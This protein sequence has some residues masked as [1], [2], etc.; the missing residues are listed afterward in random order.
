MMSFTAKAAA[1]FGAAALV[2]VP[3]GV[4]TASTS[5]S[6]PAASP[7]LNAPRHSR[8][9]GG[10]GST[11]LNYHGGV[12]DGAA[13]TVGVETTPGVYIVFWG[14][15][16]NNNDPSGEANQVQNFLGG[17]YQ[18]GA[19]TNDNWSLSTTQ[20]CQGVANGATSC[21]AGTPVTAP[22][23]SPVLGVWSDNTSAAPSKPR[24]SQLAG[25]AVRA[26]GHFGNAS[27]TQ[28]ASVQYVIATAHGNNAQGFGTS[29]C[30]WHSSVNSSAGQIAYTNLPYITDAG[31]SC[32][33]NFVSSAIDGITIVEGHE[34]AETV[35][36]QYPNGGWLDGSGAENGDKCA[37]ISPGSPGGSAAITLSTGTFAVQ[38]L[39]SNSLPGC[40]VYYP[41]GGSGQ[42]G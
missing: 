6:P 39:W 13:G 2:L 9:T 12:S 38:S 18:S 29:Y 40:A 36:D 16:W 3:A 5:T 22:T 11:L 35:T 1:L 23:A 14:S 37:W 33:A 28:N 15:Q 17:L 24:Q 19:S 42:H 26:A 30:A 34:Y 25:E 4:S 41:V 32:G 21:S 20:Y 27:A 7:H 8:P 31:A 10:G